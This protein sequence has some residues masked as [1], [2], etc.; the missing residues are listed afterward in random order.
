MGVDIPHKA[1]QKSA[2]R[3]TNILLLVSFFIIYSS[4]WICHILGYYSTIILHLQQINDPLGSLRGDYLCQDKS[5]ACFSTNSDIHPVVYGVNFLNS[6]FKF[7]SL[8]FSPVRT[9]PI[10]YVC[11]DSSNEASTA[12]Y[13]SIISIISAGVTIKC[14]IG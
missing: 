7:F 1:Q 9:S 2:D 3:I 10:T 4:P 13:L 12:T 14:F 6:A 5:Q 11:N 8:V